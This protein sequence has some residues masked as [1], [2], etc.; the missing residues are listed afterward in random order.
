MLRAELIRPLPDLLKAHA[1]H[2]GD[3]V[4]FSDPWRSVTYA[5]LEL[6]TRRL[7]GHLAGLVPRGG[8]VAI[9]LGNRVEVIESYLAITRASAV[10]VPLNP[11]SS[12]AEIAHFLSDSGAAVVITDAAHL[13]Q[14]RRLDVRSL[15]VVGDSVPADALSFSVLASGG[16][17]PARDDLGLDEPAWMLYTSGTTG[18]PKGV[19]STQRS[20][21]WSV[22]A[23]Y[24]PI[25]GLSPSDVVL[26]P[27]PLFHSLAHGLC[28]LGVT[29]VGATAR[30]QSGFSVE[31]VLAELRSDVTF[32]AGVPTMY[33]QLVRAGGVASGLR[34]CLTAGSVCSAALSAGF[35]AAFGVPLLDGYGSTETCGMIAVNWP[36]GLR[37]PGSCGLPVPGV[38]VRLV[39]SSGVDVPCGSEGEVW[40][41]GPN[42]MTGYHNQPPALV[43]G[44]YR[45]GDLA[46]RDP[47]GYLTITGRTKELIIRGG[48]NIHPAEIERVLLQLPGVLDAA[49]AG[50]PDDVLGEV[51]VA[52]VVP[53]LDFDPASVLSGCRAQLSAAKVPAELREVSDV[54]RTPS[55]KI[56]RHRLASQP[57]RLRASSRPLHGVEWVPVVAAGSEFDLT[58]VHSGDFAAQADAWLASDP[59][60]S[61]RFVIVTRRAIAVN[62]TEGV[63]DLAAASVWGLARP[64]RVVLV[65][66]DT[67][68]V[69]LPTVVASGE[70]QLAVRDGV[71]LAPRLV[72]L[73]AVHE[74]LGPVAVLGSGPMAGELPGDCTPSEAALIIH[75]SPE[76]ADLTVSTPLVLCWPASRPDLGAF[77]DAAARHRRS[78]GLP[79]VSLEWGDGAADVLDALTTSHTCLRVTVPATEPSGTPLRDRLTSLSPPERDTVLLEI[80]RT[81]AARL[82]SSPLSVDRP[83]RELGLSSLG[84]VELRNDLVASTGVPLDTTC[85]FDHPTCSAL[86]AHLHAQLFGSVPA[87]DVAAP[88]DEPIAIVG[89]ACRYPGG[90]RSPED[91][92][93]LVSSEVDAIGPFPS[94]RGWDLDA[95]DTRFGGFLH[96]AGSFDADFFG[97][98]PREALSTDPQQ[99]LLLEVS[100]EAFEHAGIDPLS[101]CGSQTGV[102]TGAMHHD[103][104]T[105]DD[106]GT[107]GSVISGRVAYTFGFEGPA[108]TVD[109]ACSSSLVSL[110]LAAQAL[111]R[112]D[113]SL[114]LAGGVAVMATP[115]TFIE[116][117]RQRALSADGRCKA[118]ASAADGTSWSEGAGV[119]LLERLSDA[120]RN[121]HRVL[122]VLRGSAINSDGASNGLTAPSGPA[123][124]RVIRAALSSAGL[125]VADVDVVE[126]HGTGTVLGDPIEAQ[127]LLATYGQR[128]DPVWL[129]SLKSNIGHTQAAAGVGGVIKMVMAMRHGLL[130]RTLHVDAPTP[131]VDW[132]SGAVSLLTASQPWPSLGRPRRAAVSSFGVS[133]T[134]A[135]VILESASRGEDRS[136]NGAMP[137]LVS[138]KTETALKAQIDQLLAFVDRH[139]PNPADVA[140]T[141][142][143]RS[144]FPHRAVLHGHTELA[145][146]RADNQ[147]VVFVFPGQ[148]SQWAGMGTQLIAESPAFA[149]RMADCAQA[150]RPHVDWNLFDV[151]E[152]PEALARVEVVQPALWAVMV[153][154]A[155]LWQTHGVE[156]KAV[157]GHSQGEI[158]AAVVAGAL[159]IEDGARVVALRAKL[160]TRLAGRGGMIAVT[161]L[162]EHLDPRLSVAAING[163]DSFVLSGDLE[164]LNTVAGKRI[165]VEYASH[166][167]HV[168]E[169]RDELLAALAGIEPREPAIPFLSTCGGGTLDAAYWYRNLRETVQYD[170]VVRELDDRILLEISPHPVLLT[171]FGTLRRDD[172]G[173]DRFRTSAAQLWVRGVHV[174]WQ[175]DGRHV[176]LPTYAFQRRRY[177]LEP[178][179]DGHPLLGTSVELADAGTKVFTARLS[180]RTWL[181]D[182][183]VSGT[184]LLPGTAF[185]EMALAA[186]EEVGYDAIDELIIETPLV[187]PA[188]GTVEVQ[189]AVDQH[190]SFT[191]HSRQGEQWRRH[192]SGTLTTAV[193][194]PFDLHEWPPA[195]ATA[196]DLRDAYDTLAAG[197][198]EYGPEFQGLTALWRRGD[199]LFAEVRLPGDPAAFGLHPALFDAA[200]HP[201]ALA[202]WGE[203]QQGQTLLPF[204]WNGVEL[205][206]AGATALRVRLTRNGENIAVQLADG[207]GL[208]VAAVQSLVLRPTPLKDLAPVNSLYRVTWT[209][210]TL[211]D[212]TDMP[213][214][215]V[216]VSPQNVH[217][218]LEQLQRWIG[219]DTRLVVLTQGAVDLDDPDPDGAAVW[220][221]VRSAQS[222]HPDRIILIDADSVLPA[223][224]A[225]GEPQ[226]MVRDGKAY[227]PRL[228]R[229]KSSTSDFDLGDG[230]VLITGGTGTLGGLLARH[231]VTKH[232]VRQLVLASRTGSAADLEAEL[233][234]RV[235]VAACDA[236]D[237]A[238]L[239]ALLDG[240]PDLTAVVHAAGVLDDGVITSLTPERLDTVLSP[241]ATAALNLHELAP[242]VPLVLF[243]SVAGVFG[244]PG[245]G[246]YAAANAFLDALAQ[247]RRSRGLPAISIAW[248][249]WERTSALTTHLAGAG[250]RDNTIAMS[251]ET[252]LALFDTALRANEPTFVAAQLDLRASTNPLLRNLIRARRPSRLS[253]VPGQDQLP[254]LLDLVRSNT[255]AV[256]GHTPNAVE[257]SRAFAELGFD[258]LTAVELRNRLSA[259]TDLRLPATLVFDHPTPQALAE[260]LHAE[261][262]G[263]RPVQVTTKQV[264]SDQPIAIVAMACRYPGGVRST[265]DLWDLVLNEVDAIG[266]FPADRGWDVDALYDADPDRVGKSSTR[267]GGFLYDAGEFDADF[268]GLSPREALAMDPQ[269]RL[270]LEV[271]WEVVERAGIDP[272]SL[273]GTETGVFTGVMYHDYASRLDEIPDDVEAYLGLGTAGSVASGRVAYSLGLEGPAITVDTACSSS[274]VALH[275]AAQALRNGE[276][277]LALA[278]GVAV[279][280][281]PATFVE[282]S[283]QRGLSPDGRCKAFAASADGT[284]W[285]EGAGVLLLERLSD[286]ERNGHPVL[287]VV[288]GSAVN[289]DGAS[290]GLTAPNGPSQ[291]RVILRAL[292]SAGLSVADV[293]LVE[294][295][296]TGTVLG[297]PIEAQA[298]LA[299]YGRRSDPVWLG[300][301]KSNV[302]HTQAAA[303]VGG[304]IKAVMAMRHGLLPRTLHVDAPSPHVDWSSGAVSLLTSARP[305]PSV[306]RPRRSAVSS[307]GVSGTNAHVILESAGAPELSDLVE[308]IGVGTRSPQGACQSESI[309]SSGRAAGEV[310]GASDEDVA[311]TGVAGFAGAGAAPLLV[312]AKSAEALRA[313]ANKLLE[314]EDVR[315]MDLG[316]SLVTTRAA[317]EHRAVV[318]GDGLEALAEGRVSPHVVEGVA[319]A[320]RRVAFLFSGQGS[321]R[322]GMGREL[323]EAFPV[324]AKAFD[325]VCAYLGYGLRDVVFG[326]GSLDRTADTQSALFAV[327]VALFRLVEWFG[328]RPDFLAGHSVGELAAAHVAGVLSLEDAAT[329]VSARGRL[330]QAL[331]AGGAMVAIQAGEREIVPLLTGRVGLAAV[332]GPDAVVISGDEGEVL[333]IAARFAKSKRLD[334]SHA[335]HSPLVEPMLDDF[336]R[337]AEGLTY[338]EPSIPVVAGRISSPDYWVEH[339]RRTVR[340]GDAVRTLGDEGVT[341]FLELGPRG[342]LTALA[343]DNLSSVDGCVFATALRD[344]HEPVALLTALAELYV[345]GV[346]VEWTR[347]FEETDA[348][349]VDLPTYAFQ[350]KRYWLDGS[351]P[352]AVVSAPERD[353]LDLVRAHA[354]VVLGH[355]SVDAVDPARAFS[356]CGFDSLMAVQL[357]NRL[358]TATGMAL[359]ATLLFDHPTPR[360]LAEHLGGERRESVEVA[361]SDEP[362]AIVGMACRYPGGVASPD[363][364]WRLVAEGRDAISGPPVDRGWEFEKSYVREGGFLHDAGE[365]DADFFGIN[366]REALAMDPQQRLLLEVSWEA[367]E[368]AGIDPLSLRG[369]KTGVFSGVVYHDYA[370]RL[371]GRVPEEVMGYLGT[372]S[373]ASVASGR[374][375][376]AFGLEGPA[377]TVDTACSSSLVALHWA[378]QALRNG[379]CSLALVGGA[380]V[381][382]TPIAFAEFSKQRALAPDGRCKPFAA[383]ADGTAWAE[384]VGVLLVER[385]S[386]AQ[387]N[388]HEVLAVMRGSAVNQDGASNGLT[389][390]NGPSQQRVIHAA[391]GAAGLSVADVDVVEA[392]GTGTALGDPIEAQALIAT[393]GQR[394]EPVW[395]GSL[396]SNIGHAQAAAGVGGV[397]KMVMAMRHGVLPR[398]LHV[399][400]PTP[401]VDWSA[402]SVELLTEARPWPAGAAPR[403]A[404]VSSFGM[405][406]TNAHV[407][408]E[409]PRAQEMSD[410]AEMIGVGTRSPQGACYSESIQRESIRAVGVPWVVSAKTEAALRAQVERLVAFVSEH[411]D[412]GAA[413]VG[414]TLAARSTFAH[415]AVLLDGAVIASGQAG[416]TGRVAFVFPGQGSQWVG[417]AVELAESSP[418]FAA[419]MGECA[420]ALGR[421]VGW[422]LFE[423]LQD[424]A[425][426]D[427]VEVVQPALWAVMVSLAGLW[428]EF[429]VEPQAVVGHSQGEI[430]AAVVAGA[431]SIEDGAKVV[432]LRSAAIAKLAGTG[433]MV[434]V[435][436]SA[437]RAAVLARRWRVHVAAVN[438]PAA[439]VLAGEV[440]ALQGLLAACEADGVHARW[441]PV[442]YASHTPHVEAVRD[443]ILEA[444]QGIEPCSAE[445][446]FY[447]T[448]TGERFDTAGLDAR[449]WYENLRNTVRFEQATKQ[450][451]E[452]GY[453]VFV[454]V[455]AHPVLT[456]GVQDVVDGTVVGSLRRDDGGWDRF[457]ESLAQ[458]WV[459]GANVDWARCCPGK[460]R[461]DLPAYAF[462][463]EHYWLGAAGHPLLGNGTSLAGSGGVLFTGKVS[464]SAHPWLADHA[465]LGSVL[466]PGTAFLELALQAAREVGCG[467][468]EEL[469]IVAPLVVP[470]AAVELQV[471]VGEADATGRRSIEVYS[472]GAEWVLHAGGVVAPGVPQEVGIEWPPAGEEI[473]VGD[474]YERLSGIG[475][476]YGPRFQGLQRV[477]RGDGEVFAEVRLQGRETGFGLHPALLDAALHAM[478]L[479]G[480]TGCEGR[481]PFAW[482]GVS[483]AASGASVLRVRLTSIASDVVSLAAVDEDGRAVVN[484]DSLVLRPVS[485]DRLVPDSL[486]AVRWTPISVASAEPPGD[487][488]EVEHVHQALAVL[489]EWAAG[490]QEPLVLVTKNATGD[491]PDLA[492]AAVWGL[493]RSAQSENP[494]RVVLV[495]V[496]DGVP[497][498]LLAAAVASGEPQLALRG[499]E[500]LVPRL[501]RPSVTDEG[502][503]LEGRVLITGGTGT[504]GGFVARHLV[505]A[506]GVTR[507]VLASRRGEAAELRAEL[508]EL[509]AEVSVVACDVA[510]RAALERL[511]AESPVDAVVHMA[512]TL[513]DGVISSLTPERVDGVWRGKADAAWYLH[514]LLPDVPTVYFSSAAGTFGGPGQANYAAANAFLDALARHRR[515]RG[516]P[517]VTLAWGLWAD[518]SGMTGHLGDADRARMARSGIRPLG[519]EEALRLFDAAL[520]CGEAVVVPVPL[521]ASAQVTV[522]PLL[523]GLIRVRT[524]SKAPVRVAGDSRQVLLGLVRDEVAG[525]LG[526]SGRVSAGRTF[527]ELG[528]DSLTA[529][530]LR[531]RLSAATGVR[532]PSTLVFDHPTVEALVEFLRAELVP[533]DVVDETDAIDDMD[534][535]DLVRLVLGTS[536]H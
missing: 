367:V 332:N 412:L 343:A 77:C 408:L 345:R 88:S 441:V 488:V 110:H 292:A 463:H 382:P 91:L 396:K 437:D 250:T 431:L 36:S 293:D 289:S 378:A 310:R 140:T 182:H 154:L 48:E 200:L 407:I 25:Y 321:Q 26:W 481:L 423:V 208:P 70:A 514:E 480:Q 179:P 155:H 404:A 401:H 82:C 461:V 231:L 273:R 452:D 89:M 379:E 218:A 485:S 436:A 440:E 139:E 174:D 132:S 20:C 486:Y 249:L 457:L 256:L 93:H 196:I 207:A 359:P 142:A 493:V 410:L 107:A 216:V 518:E 501:A 234:A 355:E 489:Q 288:R 520:G 58:I 286:A 213:D 243:S 527:K 525:V 335:F 31:A 226:L 124:Q 294:A 227:A 393:Y 303:G 189:L 18:K 204:S 14:L 94:D 5:D 12:S 385:L 186:G 145:S 167:A 17:A 375:A 364:L 57:S 330:M 130:P 201:I 38:S 386:D 109:T 521:D 398:T 495:D 356:E 251:D 230:T 56:F 285:S 352:T 46:R 156:P 73:P 220:G 369:S 197:G 27:A 315:R 63:L 180:Q 259:A 531:N 474:L 185:V 314:C 257:P 446:D 358:S 221:L 131:H 357:R 300:S 60:P 92:W 492:G 22:A 147:E 43:D 435:A 68:T 120:R 371:Y 119:V 242:T 484:V 499:N 67:D 175:F 421:W 135:H 84:A 236:A 319:V 71:V 455:S 515:A 342:V 126:A 87:V 447:S 19:L 160:I 494:G 373:A 8:R 325:E 164:V 505:V 320:G 524:E 482:N 311:R 516:L 45:T 55:G 270:L 90:V 183:A 112:G 64:N 377:V 127:A 333:A 497:E 473:A 128:P 483:L 116:F 41:S 44:W 451:A 254:A 405:S 318:I 353:L 222:E 184:V 238:E 409:A 287:A 363:D 72:R 366:P 267:H 169:L 253:A 487:V 3:K 29:A 426:L 122:A 268:F 510:D 469:T 530:E 162:P 106:I 141:L 2:S 464:L 372:G 391:L 96:D 138:A 504:L 301:L 97:I 86:A 158:A 150:L 350:R 384:G 105:R 449:Y 32:L 13:D 209:P 280:A 279:M 326:G 308:M 117:S 115:A 188:G 438:G 146:G 312:S 295:H 210:I 118:F 394:P 418:V 152:D 532:L 302:G 442:D 168:E 417:M 262:R 526:I 15:I 283:R 390:P 149:Q 533:N 123:Q 500:V 28:V 443:E 255:A 39:D 276:C 111:R 153:S 278:G 299:T 203:T 502:F 512:G 498:G 30:I 306:D 76:T 360:A 491:D 49:V 202:G 434:S 513:D 511:L 419:R 284:G 102:F 75:T 114:A 380:T 450:L 406:G 263:T 453:G 271:S 24:A 177:W 313:Q 340:F 322:P 99:R 137:W 173:Q 317:L 193:M 344:G 33:H 219:E 65:D 205:F 328:V 252:G 247:H 101:L 337:V 100:W 402:G 212:V 163:P 195:N 411:P 370:A 66:T 336:R 275:W 517:A 108:I 282:F 170:P 240:I 144:A 52:Y 206:T 523:R 465:V 509:G 519:T 508:E 172:G 388:G 507:L 296:G 376:Y 462:Q 245:Q 534:T 422:E 241:K 61:A 400:E 171:G 368:R 224:I 416:G 347:F 467:V 34:V 235:T 304:V 424:A 456:I 362:I 528:F 476:D 459:G 239:A 98:S 9:L 349:R 354:A 258:S 214:D 415:R 309:P 458:A 217:A 414:G 165:P 121:G 215:V 403:R 157:I 329:L 4:A 37:V 194:K 392:H 228:E 339:V 74:S 133:G 129:G 269:Q 244:S 35:E 266:E 237:R 69:D 307:F 1:A 79:A 466:L 496:E 439:T 420:K 429:G 233:G 478:F 506:H 53:G 265:E 159:S 54:P 47:Q 361:R 103:Y 445:I 161:A 529:V 40:V 535:D 387:R 503:R 191:V 399:D 479:D 281:T 178:G 444:L 334:V 427:R 199:E 536:G 190:G 413:E 246:N 261:L 232:G 472:R 223:A 192:A 7:A 433:G 143:T 428:R 277:S 264:S 290:N 23:C 381:M 432:C 83:F 225:A 324:F 248:G 425:A 85:A 460:Q 341:A 134:N 468:V 477:W 338:R 323:Y 80:V 475:F 95:L 260:R 331:P 395:L 50:K 104:G 59:A 430:A 229:A 470:E 348:R 297:D 448:L 198:Y 351:A 490:E 16:S 522:H 274:L 291:E 81:A 211:P 471:V 346:P 305:W 11:D 181:A 176:D 125:S 166:S 397:I 151:L 272:S 298:L 51:P 113:C 374:V 136:G 187:L 78:Q 316:Y 365:F 62:D 21:L 42:L 389:A 148:G 327:E 454:E 6:R 383:S 10:G